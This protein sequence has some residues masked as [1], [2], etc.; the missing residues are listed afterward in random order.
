MIASDIETL[1]VIHDLFAKIGFEKFSIRVNNRL[2]LNGALEL[3]GHSGQTA[4]VLRALD[5]LHKIGRDA[6][7]AEMQEAAGTTPEQAAK[8]LDV[9]GVS[10]SHDAIL[11]RLEEL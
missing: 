2:I 5:K 7:I 1:L 10:G 8:V 4:R 3:L 6:V 9:S 11:T